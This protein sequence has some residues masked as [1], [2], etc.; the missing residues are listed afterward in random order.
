MISVCMATYNGEKYIKEQVDSILNQ[1]GPNDELIVSDDGSSDN[2][3]QILKDIDDSR[4]KIFLNE[5]VHGFT[6]NFEN[7]IRKASGDYIFLSDQDDVWRYDKVKVTMKYLSE[8][9]LVTHDCVTVNERLDIIKDSRFKE[10]NIKPGFIRHLIKS[11]FLG[12]CIAFNKKVLNVILPFPKN[13]KLLEHD[14][15]IV[16]VAMLYYKVKLVDE[17]LVFY[18]R[19]GNNVSDGGFDKGYSAFNKVIRR[20]YRLLCL[21]KV[22]PKVL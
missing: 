13:D 6:Q 22:L 7:A 12:C 4:I 11:R 15:W 9:D 3:V 20:I 18:R 16:A 2:T 21:V 10:F 14:I 17:P 19:H 1:I 5:G 8:F